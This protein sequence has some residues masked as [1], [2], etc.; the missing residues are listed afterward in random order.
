ML[1]RMRGLL[2]RSHLEKDG[3][4]ILEPAQSIHTFFMAFAIDVVFLDRDLTVVRVLPNM[5]PFRASPFV[6]SARSTIELPPGMI[7][8]TQTR[9]GDRLRFEE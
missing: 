6:R 4:L 2:G 3:G 1:K 9:V 5:R 8:K 7:E